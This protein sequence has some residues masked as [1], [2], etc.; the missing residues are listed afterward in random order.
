[1]IQ[2]YASNR[3]SKC[4]QWDKKI[5]MKSYDFEVQVQLNVDYITAET[6][7]NIQLR[8]CNTYPYISKH[9]YKNKNTT[10]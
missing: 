7:F 1:M 5:N 6:H 8:Y 3:I 2:S 9:G 10:T 4:I